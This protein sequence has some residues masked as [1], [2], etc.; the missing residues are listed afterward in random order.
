MNRINGLK[1]KTSVG[2]VCL[3]YLVNTRWSFSNDRI[4][5][6][7]PSRTHSVSNCLLRIA[8]QAPDHVLMAEISQPFENGRKNK[9]TIPLN[10]N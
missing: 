6:Q 1:M 2:L 4:E 3:Q 10:I 5:L 8:N 7:E 9:K